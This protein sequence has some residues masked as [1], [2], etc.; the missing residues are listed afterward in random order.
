MVTAP[1]NSTG[2]LAAKLPLVA[3][4]LMLTPRLM[5]PV[6]AS[7]RSLNLPATVANGC[8]TVMPPVLEPEPTTKVAAVRLPR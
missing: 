3:V 1:V 5:L 6:E 4:V 8:D 2:P 7:V